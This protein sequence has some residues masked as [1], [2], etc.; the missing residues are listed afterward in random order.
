MTSTVDRGAQLT[1]DGSTFGGQGKVELAGTLT[2]HSDAGGPTATFATRP[3]AVATADPGTSARIAPCTGSGGGQLDRPGGLL[4][5]KHSGTLAIDG[6]GVAL[7]DGYHLDVKGTVAVT[8]A[9]YVVADRGTGTAIEHGGVFRFENDGGYYEGEARFGATKLSTF[10]NKGL[11]VKTDGDGVSAVDAAYPELGGHILIKSGTLRVHSGTN[12]A[13]RVLAGSSYGS[14]ECRHAGGTFG[15]R[16]R[17]DAEDVQNAMLKVPPTDQDGAEVTVQEFDHDPTLYA[18]GNAVKVHAEELDATKR[19]P[20]IL[21]FRYDDSVLRQAAS[22]RYIHIYRNHDNTGYRL[23]HRCDDHGRPPKGEQACVD[24]RQIPGVSS[25]DK[26]G[27]V[28]MVVR[29][30]GTSRWIA[31]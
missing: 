2:W 20:A 4:V 21:T 28:I 8:E 10:A 25:R 18:I 6:S 9:G 22:W 13:A 30:T 26:A 3:C 15:C 27:D 14:G 7:V 29:A 5:V 12:V 17:T 1:V 19:H 11:L 16:P 31:R 23:V 24:R